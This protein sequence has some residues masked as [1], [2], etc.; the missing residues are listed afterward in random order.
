LDHWGLT[1]LARPKA[2]V[3]VAS[4]HRSRQGLAFHQ[5]VLP[6]D[7][8]TVHEGV[9]ITTVARTLFDAAATES[10]ARLR[11]VVAIAEVRGLADSPSLPELLERYPGARGTARLRDA[12]TSAGSEGVADH[13]LELRFAEF[14]DECGLPRPQKN[15]PIE[16]A[17]GRTLIVDCLWPEAD[18]VV[19]LDSRTHHADWEAAETDRARDAALIA[20]GLRSLRVTWR[21]LHDARAQLELEL[22]GAL[23]VHVHRGRRG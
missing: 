20:V 1:G 19:E 12:I 2:H 3:A 10:P 22:L 8:R 5:L 14:I 15:V 13:E 16:V 6:S 11:Q 17:G 21:R 7:E 23:E 9:P 4:H 18:L